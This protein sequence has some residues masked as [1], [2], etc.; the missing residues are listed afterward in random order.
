[1]SIKNSK[2]G[3]CIGG[4][5]TIDSSWQ[6]TV[7]KYYADLDEIKRL[8]FTHVR[9]GSTDPTFSNAYPLSKAIAEYAKSIGLHTTWGI[10][11]AASTLTAANYSTYEAYVIAAAQYAEA[12]GF[13]AFEIANEIESTND[14]TTLTDADLIATYLPS[15]AVLV[16]AEF[17]GEVR[18]A[19]TSGAT[20]VNLWI[21]Q[22][23]TPGTDI[24]KLSFNIYGN[25]QTDLSGFQSDAQRIF[26]GFGTDSIVSE[27]NLVTDSGTLSISPSRQEEEMNK[28]IGILDSIG[29]ERMYAFVWKMTSPS[30]VCALNQSDDIIKQWYYSLIAGRRSFVTI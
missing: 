5:G 11:N 15:T 24:D 4:Y 20:I 16:Q 8:G 28:R 7:S 14:N 3:M 12:Q 27:F 2:L 10:T 30:E 22:G 25:S 29:F 21:A 6:D 26:D 17:S 23:I 18:C 9:I 1:M 19:S 13:D